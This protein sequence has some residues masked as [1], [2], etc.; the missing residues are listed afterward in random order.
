MS[1]QLKLTYF[2]ASGRAEVSRLILNYGK[3]DFVDER[4]SGEEFGKRKETLPFKQLPVLQIDGTTTIAQSGAI[5]RYAAQL[6]GLTPT[7]PVTMAQ[8]EMTYGA[9]EHIAESFI[10]IL[11]KIKDEAQ[12]REKTETF[13]K[14]TLPLFL[15]KI[16]SYATNNGFVHGNSLTV[17]DFI[18]FFYLNNV[19]IPSFKDF[20]VDQYPKLKKVANNIEALPALAAY[21]N[22]SVAEKI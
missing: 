5:N 17:V 15:G 3:I 14:D 21:L 10:E 20:D 22:K 2:D 7:N 12:K 11:Y 13:L 6:A 19:L 8:V 16:E 9:Y 18:T 4:I 1:P